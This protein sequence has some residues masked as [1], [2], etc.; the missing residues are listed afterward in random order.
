MIER[1]N[2]FQRL[3]KVAYNK[4]HDIKLKATQDTLT[5]EK[6]YPNGVIKI[7]D[8]LYSKSIRFSDVGY[9]LS[10]D[11]DKTRTFTL[12]CNLLN[13]FDPE[14]K[15]QFSFIN[16]KIEQTA[17]KDKS[18]IKED[19]ERLKKLQD[20]YFLFVERQREKGNNGITRNKYLTFTIHLF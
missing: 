3:K 17:Y 18:A 1:K 20:E 11:E 5:F 2:L 8:N 6:I 7:K 10:K 16:H 15:F 19:E 13:W 4:K 14:V 9:Q 12:Y